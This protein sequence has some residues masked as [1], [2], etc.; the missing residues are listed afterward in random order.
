MTP[1]DYD[2]EA[3]T[4]EVADARLGD[5]DAIVTRISR[6]FPHPVSDVW[7]AVTSPARLGRWFADIS[8]DLRAGGRF[9]VA[10]SAAGEVRECDAPRRFVVTWA[11][12]GS[13]PDEPGEVQVGLTESDGGTTLQLVHTDVIEPEF[14]N[15]FGPGAG[16]VGW[17]L[18]FLGL[19]L[20]LAG[21]PDESV[22]IEALSSS[23]AGVDVIEK[24]SAAWARAAME[25]GTTPEDAVAAGG[26]TT[27]FYTGRADPDAAE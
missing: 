4:R 13:A 27:A 18:A 11:S 5:R 20:H 21:G 25:V 17:D 22:D 16:G 12:A 23:E 15:R 2:A 26:R 9:E 1:E 24:A 7:D 14:W 6:E 19:A 10:G 8:G 3:V